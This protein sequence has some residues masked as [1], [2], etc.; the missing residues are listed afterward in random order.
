[1]VK[2]YIMPV[3]MVLILA[4]PCSSYGTEPLD[5]LR[6]PVDQVTAL[7][8]D[9]K[10]QNPE[11]KELQRE[12]IWEAI[13]RVFDFREMAKR[14]LGRNWNKFTPEQ[15]KE[16]THLFSELLGNMYTTKMQGKY[17]DEKVVYLSQKIASGSKARVK[18]KIVSRNMDIPVNYN[19]I[20]RNG[21]WKVYDVNIEGISLI[22]N[23]RSQFNQILSK[24]SPTY[25][26]DRLKGKIEIQK[27][28]RSEKN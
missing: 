9:P 28:K 20:K 23:Y 2:N 7:L 27:K 3:I 10:Y 24:D 26:I 18:T 25:L 13:T 19:M 5:A 21:S 16:F 1:M 17:E 6:I 8:K 11:Q 22:K 4:I 12:K 14:A 15:R